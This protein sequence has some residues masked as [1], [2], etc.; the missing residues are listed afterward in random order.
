M[1]EVTATLDRE[2]A[3][4]LAGETVRV[5]VT[6]CNL[7]R[8]KQGISEQLAWGSLQLICERTIGASSSSSTST[9]SSRPRPTTS[10]TKSAA[11]VYS[12]PPNILFCELQLAPG[13]SKQFT[14]DIP[15]SRN[16]IPPT[17]R[18]HLIKYSNRVTVAVSH[19][20]EHIKSA[21]LP[22]RIIP[23]VGLETKLSIHTNPFLASA[24]TR[25]SVVETV[26]STVD[27][28]TQ[29]RKSLAFALT[30][31]SSTSRVALLTLPKKA[32]KLGDD[33]CGFLDFNGATTPCVQ[34]SATIETEEHLI[35]ADVEEGKK[36]MV[37]VHSQTAPICTFSPDSTFR[38]SIPLTATPTF[39]TDSVQLKWKIR[40]VFVVTEQAY[41]VHLNGDVASSAAPIDVPVESFSWSTDLLVLPCKPQN[42]ALIDNTFPNRISMTV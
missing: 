10:V 3:I 9:A 42:A 32:Y 40:F 16:G 30:H 39:S 36:K 24:L 12:S 17:F 37:K 14:C 15:L 13:Q 4:Y 31:N 38:L 26:M 11:T 29:A 18:G 27:D 34:Y 7:S 33:V 41:D 2:V 19:V 28:L 20:Q 22:I 23:S 1:L 5:T 21:H 35:D 8:G 25:P 6:V